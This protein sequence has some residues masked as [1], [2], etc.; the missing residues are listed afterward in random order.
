[1]LFLSLP[2]KC[3]VIKK[4]YRAEMKCTVIRINKM[5]CCALRTIQ[6]TNIK[7][8]FLPKPFLDISLL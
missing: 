8:S 1:M 3:F 5:H 2:K 7:I 6:S 4:N